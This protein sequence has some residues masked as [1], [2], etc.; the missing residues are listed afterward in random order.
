MRRLRA[1]I[2]TTAKG[3]TLVIDPVAGTYT[4]TPSVAQLWDA[5]YIAATY[6]DIHETVTITVDDGHGG[7]LSETIIVP[8]DG[9]DPSARPSAAPNTLL[10]VPPIR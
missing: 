7:T 4:Y 10:T 1:Q 5:S 8:I 3:A 2:F 6:D 9:I